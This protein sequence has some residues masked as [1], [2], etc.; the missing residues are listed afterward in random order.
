MRATV[1]EYGITRRGEGPIIG[2]PMYSLATAIAYNQDMFARAGIENPTDWT[3]EE[4]A[5][6]PV[7]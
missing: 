5:T 6:S 7:D 2:L 4:Y 1:D 3:Y